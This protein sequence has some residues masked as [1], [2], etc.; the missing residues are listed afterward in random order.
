MVTFTNKQV[1]VLF[2]VINGVTTEAYLA[3]MAAAAKVDDIQTQEFIT[4][5]SVIAAKLSNY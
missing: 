5:F 1:A 3:A 4:E 2:H